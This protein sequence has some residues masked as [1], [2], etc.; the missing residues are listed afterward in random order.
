MSE[1][2]FWLV[3]NPMGGSPTYR[4]PDERSAKHEAERLAVQSKGTEFFV[5]KATHRAVRP[6]GAIVTPLYDEMPF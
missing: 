1:K 4:H 2:V 5:V 3:W 6:V